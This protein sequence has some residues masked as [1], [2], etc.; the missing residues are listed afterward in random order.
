VAL[1]EGGLGLG[2][3]AVDPAL[4]LEEQEGVAGGPVRGSEEVGPALGLAA[5]FVTG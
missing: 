3:E 2:I 5:C 4:L 1:E